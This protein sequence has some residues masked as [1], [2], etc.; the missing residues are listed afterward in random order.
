M[1][2]LLGLKPGFGSVGCELARLINY[3]ERSAFVIEQLDAEKHI[4]GFQLRLTRPEGEGVTVACFAA[5][6]DGE[7]GQIRYC[8]GILED[9]SKQKKIEKNGMV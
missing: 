2:R 9:I 5:L 1:R 4:E 8:D 6:V 3:K 7:D